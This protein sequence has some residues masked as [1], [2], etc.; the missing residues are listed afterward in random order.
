MAAK[1]EL[2]NM[3]YKALTHGVFSP[4]PPPP[5]FDIQ[6]NARDVFDVVSAEYNQAYDKLKSLKTDLFAPPPLPPLPPPAQLSFQSMVMELCEGTYND[7]LESYSKVLIAPVPLVRALN[8]IGLV[9]I[10]ALDTVFVECKQVYKVLES[11]AKGLFATALALAPDWPSLDIRSLGMELIKNLSVKFGA[12]MEWLQ[13]LI[14][15]FGATAIA[16]LVAA[17][18][19][20]DCIREAIKTKQATIITIDREL[21]PFVSMA[22]VFERIDDFSF[23]ALDLAEMKVAFIAFKKA[24]IDNNKKKLGD[25]EDDYVEETR[26]ISDDPCIAVLCDLF[27]NISPQK[28]TDPKTRA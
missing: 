27:A 17:L 26:D 21:K 16:L 12:I 15:R 25:K 8:D 11:C 3:K 24:D 14:R 28:G 9:A 2:V 18:T 4:P 22:A 7:K 10:E 23:S 20:V 13:A 5:T 19:I 1:V 6:T